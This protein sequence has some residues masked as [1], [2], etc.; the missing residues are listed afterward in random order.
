MM[1]RRELLLGGAAAFAA[2]AIGRPAWAATPEA[3]SSV[4]PTVTAAAVPSPFDPFMG[5]SRAIVSFRKS[6]RDLVD[7]AAGL[8]RPPMVVV[9]G[10]TG[11][12]KDFA[13]QVIHSAGR[14]STGPFVS[15]HIPSI[16]SE[17]LEPELFGWVKGAF[18]DPTEKSGV[19]EDARGGVVYLDQMGQLSYEMWPKVRQIVQTGAVWRIGETQPRDT[20]A[21]TIASCHDLDALCEKEQIGLLR[22]YYK[23]V[24]I[25]V[26]PLRARGDDIQLLADHFLADACRAFHTPLKVLTVGARDALDA[27][28][29]P[30]NLRELC[31]VIE[32]AVVL[33]EDQEIGADDLPSDFLMWRERATGPRRRALVRRAAARRATPRTVMRDAPDRTASVTPAASR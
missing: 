4:A 15:R 3:T 6:L 22:T 2:A 14:R 29:W 8:P 24:C 5:E 9:L 25:T 13:A 1:T 17:L 20:D 7:R 31:N 30:G 16:P 28:V 27:Y 32:R 12:G 10:E 26:P 23:P 33:C 18:T 21:W 19:W 11:A